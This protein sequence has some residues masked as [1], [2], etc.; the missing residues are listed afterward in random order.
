M[1]KQ[2]LPVPDNVTVMLKGHDKNNEIF[3]DAVDSGW[4]VYFA[5]T[6]DGELS[7]YAIDP[8]CDGDFNDADDVI[9]RRTVHCRKCGQ[10][11]TADDF[12]TDKLFV[13]SYIKPYSCNC[14]TTYNDRDGWNLPIV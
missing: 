13:P 2:F 12:P 1:K 10:R 14:G 5:L 11:M 8:Y 3:F 6:D 7:V 4:V 9:L